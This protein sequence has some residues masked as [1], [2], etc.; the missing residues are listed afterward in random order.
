MHTI[1]YRPDIDGLRALAVVPVILFHLGLKAIPGG[2]L[3][4]DVF[5]VI[6]GYLIA[7]LIQAEL[8]TGTFSFRQFWARRV[9]RIVP[10]LLTVLASSLMAGWLFLSRVEHPLMGREAL[11]ALFGVA[12][13]SFVWH[14]GSY[15]GRAAEQSLF[16]QTW[17]LAVEEQFYLLFPLIL[18]LCS[19]SRWVSARWPLAAIT[20]VSFFL[21]WRGST[22]S[23]V[24]TFYLLPTRAWELATGALLAELCGT[25]RNNRAPHT[26]IA[27]VLAL[28]GMALICGSYLF[29]STIGGGTVLAVGGTALVIGC[30]HRGFV[31]KLL[32]ITPLLHVGRISYSLYLWHWPLIVFQKKSEF[33]MNSLALLA[34]TYGISLAT[35]RMV[36]Q[37]CRKRSTIG[38]GIG[39]AYLSIVGL[40]G[41][42][43]C[44]SG[45]YDTSQF[46][47][48]VW[49]GEFY[50]VH[51]GNSGNRRWQHIL[52]GVDAPD[53]IHPSGEFK[54]GG[55]IVGPSEG[56]PRVVVL[57]DSHGCMWS[58]AI[59]TV[60]DRIG[61]KT[62]FWSMAG[63]DPFILFPPPHAPPSWREK[64][65]Y[66]LSRLELIKQW[67]PDLVV[68]CARWSG[69]KPKQF[70]GLLAFLAEHSRQVVI[71]EQPPE[72]AI[73]NQSLIQWLCYKGIQPVPDAQHLLGQGRV[74]LARQSQQWMKDLVGNHANCQILHTFDLYLRGDKVLC[75]DGT[76]VLYVDDDH[77]NTYGTQRTIPRIEEVITRSLLPQPISNG[78]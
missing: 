28:A 20:A 17:S 2:F 9:R 10:A 76:A 24:A 70:E 5:F 25:T 77:L 58:K 68:F 7:S 45:T 32:S 74:D 14:T 75:L 66:D 60:T 71:M 38:A 47:Q 31:G 6:S 12:N 4:V 18:W 8:V 19:K 37:P 26:A 11:A 72:L 61:V 43:A 78:Q 16:L 55:Y 52:A 13:I 44:S 39:F 34:L 53:R 3:G 46:Q 23:P 49:W 59:H 51:P 33:P 22:Q 64:Y 30:A 27:S 21:F 56:P 63:V 50:D 69:K 54:Q 1:P 42:F 29:A 41:L 48:S 67:K 62:A 73:G 36:E 57:G 65:E 35:Y 15:W 40:A